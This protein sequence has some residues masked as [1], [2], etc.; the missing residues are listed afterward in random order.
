MC[1]DLYCE[2]IEL[3]ISKDKMMVCVD[4]RQ[5]IVYLFYHLCLQVECLFIEAQNIFS[6]WWGPTMNDLTCLY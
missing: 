3:I 2:Y 5:I 6:F 1:L 4:N